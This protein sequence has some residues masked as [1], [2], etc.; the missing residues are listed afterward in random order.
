L[1]KIGGFMLIRVAR[2][3]VSLAAVALV[4]LAGSA[5]SEGYVVSGSNPSPSAEPVGPLSGPLEVFAAAPLTEALTDAKGKL[6]A[7]DP[8]LALNFNF[9]DGP[10]LVK[11]IQGNTPGST[12]ADVFVTNDQADMQQLTAANLVSVPS[13][14]ARD[15]LQIAVVAGNPKKIT[16]LADLA[17]PDLKVALIDAGTAAGKYT[18]VALD[19]KKIVVKPK[20]APADA[21]AALLAVTSGQADATVVYKTDLAL[22]AGGQVAGVAIPDQDNVVAL[23]RIAVL[24][25]AHNKVAAQA[26]TD[27]LVNGDGQAVMAAHGYLAP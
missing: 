10:G 8:K 18:M 27:Y 2:P 15:K 26:F 12:A 11:Q 16:A 9:S 24:K 20:S 23:C 6:G 13:I 7:S 19:R 5:C 3:L 25:N 21:K 22:A 17:R 14:F 1:K 4:A